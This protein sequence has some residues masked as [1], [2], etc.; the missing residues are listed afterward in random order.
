MKS[1]TYPVILSSVEVIHDR[2]NEMRF[3]DNIFDTLFFQYTNSRMC[4]MTHSI[5]N[6]EF[7]ERSNQDFPYVIFLIIII[8]KYIE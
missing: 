5:L 8:I 7:L 1:A 6:E 4:F 2:E 3:L